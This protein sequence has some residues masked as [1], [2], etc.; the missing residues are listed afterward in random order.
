MRRTLLL[1][2][3]LACSSVA[4][5][6]DWK[7]WS[8]AGSARMTVFRT[9]QTVLA[10]TSGGVISWDPATSTGKVLTNLD[11]LPTLDIASLVS[12]SAGNVW[13]AGSDGRMAFLQPGAS[14]WTSVGSYH[15]SGWQFSPGAATFWNGHVVLGGPQGL[16]LFSTKDLAAAD[17]VSAFGSLRDTVTAVYASGDSLWVATPSG[18]AIA[19]DPVWGTDSAASHLG[20]A[21]YFLNSVK[22]TF[23]RPPLPDSLRLRYR[24]RR[25]S[26]GVH[27]VLEGQWS[28]YDRSL[29]GLKLEYGL[30]TAPDVQV[31][32]PGA[33]D[34]VRTPWGYFLSSSTRGL[35]Q[36]LADGTVRSLSPSGVL[37]DALPVAVAMSSDGTP[38]FLSGDGTYTRVWT[39]VQSGDWIPDT[40]RAALPKGGAVANISWFLSGDTLVP[41]KP[42]A[43][44]PGGEMVVGSWEE[45][46]TGGGFLVSGSAGS[47]KIWNN[48]NDTCLALNSANG[49]SVRSLHPGSAGV[50]GSLFVNDPDRPLVHLPSSGDRTPGCL[51]VDASPVLGTTSPS[52]HANDL[53]E[54]GDSLWLATNEGLLRV[55]GIRT[56]PGATRSAT[57]V[58]GWTR[59]ESLTR[60]LAITANGT[61]WI[62]AVG[63]GF[64]GAMPANATASDTFQASQKTSQSYLALAQDA[65]GHVWAAGNL[66]LD[67]WT[68]GV[69]D[70]GTLKF[71]LSRTIRFEDGLPNERIIGLGLDSATGRAIIA[72]SGALALWTSPYRPVPSR[73]S[74][75][76]IR[77]WPNPVRLRQHRSLFVDGATLSAEFD[78]F[79]ADGTRVMHQESS[80]SAT[81]QIPLPTTNKL[82]PGI[83]YWSLKDLRGSVHGPLLVGE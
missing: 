83:Y 3:S 53:L 23:V 17:Y 36:I 40:I 20:R 9:G 82:R 73:L 68:P 25:D 24:I 32:V 51:L 35:V 48:A 77:V 46:R 50:W 76:S 59:Q 11:G 63:S 33:L 72:T 44:G 56:T 6:G 37:P 38:S 55:Q 79:S 64:L 18:M 71:T 49:V 13:A 62:V 52:F 16:T 26:T 45:P 29:Q 65:V 7:I 10:A 61:R 70:S 43:R 78:L 31:D 30:F 47:W 69:T 12:D 21:G 67:I 22:W 4:S 28:D 80:Q 41:A 27:Q 2:L 34:A 75:S 5:T 15:S 58:V 57:K 19:T 14:F 1:P 66:G 39:R 81:I 74:R 42:L 8:M 60:L 54:S